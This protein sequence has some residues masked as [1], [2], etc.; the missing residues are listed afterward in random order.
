[1]ADQRTLHRVIFIIAAAVLLITVLTGAAFYLGRLSEG[2]TGSA[3]PLYQGKTAGAWSRQLKDRDYKTRRNAAL[4]LAEIGGPN[5]PP[6]AITAVE[7]SAHDSDEVVRVRAAIILWEARQDPASLSFLV[8]FVGTDG[9]TEHFVAVAEAARALGRI[10][11]PAKA[12]LPALDKLSR[13]GASA[14][15]LGGY[16]DVQIAGEEAED[17]AARIRAK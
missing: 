8:K 12:A 5:L 1:M 2:G 11:P 9:D 15:R 16:T 14:K 7:Q 10:G 13:S 6:S 3:G 17:A 4:A